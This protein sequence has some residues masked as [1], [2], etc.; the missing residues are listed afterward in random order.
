MRT[1]VDG[2]GRLVIPKAVR[3]AVGLRAG[4]EVDIAVDGVNIV[5]TVPVVEIGVTTDAK[6]RVQ[7]DLADDDPGP[8][9]TH[10]DMLRAIDE[11][12]R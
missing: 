3:T 10:E 4:S 6:G 1:T 7:T 9:A 8:F 5:L 11:Q 2:A 12:R